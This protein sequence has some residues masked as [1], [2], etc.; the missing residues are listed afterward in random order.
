[1]RRSVVVA[2]SGTLTLQEKVLSFDFVGRK[3][4]SYL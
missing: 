3:V 1:L 2:P 4:A